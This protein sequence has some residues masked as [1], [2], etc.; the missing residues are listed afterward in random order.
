MNAPTH[1]TLKDIARDLRAIAEILEE[2][3]V[4]TEADAKDSLSDAAMDLETYGH[5][6]KVAV[7]TRWPD[8]QALCSGSDKHVDWQG[9]PHFFKRQAA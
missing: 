3:E 4:G 5:V 8:S 7:A 2:A 9:L 6:L 1:L